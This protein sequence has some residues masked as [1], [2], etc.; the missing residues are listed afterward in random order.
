MTA[1]YNISG[2]LENRALQKLFKRLRLES[3][4]G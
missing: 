3:S 2:Y 1:K 4:Q